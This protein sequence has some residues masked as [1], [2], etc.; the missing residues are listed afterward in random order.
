MLVLIA[1]DGN[2]TDGATNAAV[3]TES[4]GLATVAHTDRNLCAKTTFFSNPKSAT[5]VRQKHVVCR[6]GNTVRRDGSGLARLAEHI[7]ADAAQ[8][9]KLPALPNRAQAH[10][11]MHQRTPRLGGFM[12]LAI[13]AVAALAHWDARRESATALASFAEEQAALARGIAATIS[14]GLES[15]RHVAISPGGL[16]L[17]SGVRSFER[18]LSS[19]LLLAR[20]GQ[21]GLR[22][23][24]GHLVRDERVESGL[25]DGTGVGPEIVK[26][27]GRQLTITPRESNGGHEPEA[28]RGTRASV[29]L[30]AAKKAA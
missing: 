30:P 12:A 24:D 11:R 10:R 21:P 6:A 28:V 4:N 7:L 22:D 15:D 14:S 20:P 1:L 23:T 27:H 25:R 17:L 9:K 2:R 19:R 8:T 18:P 13:I 26:H 29:E 16:E 5:R 3:C